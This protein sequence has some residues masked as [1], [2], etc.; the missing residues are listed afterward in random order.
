MDKKKVQASFAYD[1]PTIP[2]IFGAPMTKATLPD[3]FVGLTSVK[4]EYTSSGGKLESLLSEV[5]G[6]LFLSD[7]FDYITY[8]EDCKKDY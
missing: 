8:E 4:I 6:L 7:N 2:E 1:A 3:K 5:T